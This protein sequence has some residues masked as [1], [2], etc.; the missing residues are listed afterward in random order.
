MGKSRSEADSHLE[1]HGRLTGKYS[2]LVSACKL[3][4]RAHLHKW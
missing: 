4:V 3:Q 2:G 1:E